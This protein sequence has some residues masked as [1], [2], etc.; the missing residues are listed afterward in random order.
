MRR[1]LLLA[2]FACLLLLTPRLLSA[3]DDPPEQ[4]GDA[5]ADPEQVP[6]DA[7]HDAETYP[8]FRIIGFTDFNY[9]STEAPQGGTSSGFFEGQFVL[10]F[11]SRLSERFTFFGEVSTTA[12]ADQFKTEIERSILK[13]DYSDKLKLSAGRYHTPINY[14]NVA[15]HHGGFLQTTISRPEMIRF[16]GEFL[17]VH[18]VGVAA[19][20]VFPAGG[21]NLNYHA[22]MGNGRG[23][24]TSRPG[25]AGDV[26]DSRAI[27][28]GFFL[29]PDALYALRIG[30]AAYV[31]RVTLDSVAY[32]E[33]IVSVHAIWTRDSPEVISE[34]VRVS[35]ERNGSSSRTS[36]AWYVQVAYRLAG[37]GSRLKPYV[38]YERM[39]IDPRDRLLSNVVP[40]K[41]TTAGVRFDAG[42]VVALKAEYRQDAE[43]QLF[44]RAFFAQLSFTF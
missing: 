8:S 36:D 2:A 23:A 9:S 30:G 5:S 4:S 21:L 20:G 6:D 16:G 27:T 38:R 42:D 29:K 41:L 40:V 13:Y 17:P 24:I 37:R 35:H 34:F 32:D 33:R 25:D 11:T 1:A 15:F 44:D 12:R 18:F 31:D 3:D 7:A 14:W 43:K 39:K 28:A 26:N 22:G 19:E 10:H